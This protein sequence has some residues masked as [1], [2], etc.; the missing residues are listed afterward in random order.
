[1][2]GA[3]HAAGNAPSGATRSTVPWLALAARI[4]LDFQ[5]SER[6]ALELGVGASFLLHRVEVGIEDPLGMPVAARTLDR[7]AF[8]VSLGPAYY[9]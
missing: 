4:S 6:W 3:L 2:A 1:L 9:F 8:A 5:L 7:F